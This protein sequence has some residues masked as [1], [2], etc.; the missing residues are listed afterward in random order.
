MSDSTVYNLTMVSKFQ[1]DRL[2]AKIKNLEGR[3]LDT[4]RHCTNLNNDCNKM[5]DLLV[6]THQAI[7]DSAELIGVSGALA[8]ARQCIGSYLDEI[9]YPS[10]QV[11]VKVKTKRKIK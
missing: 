6:F 8:A 1:V 2:N 11:P 9:G 4:R 7:Q 5:L 3:L 10:A